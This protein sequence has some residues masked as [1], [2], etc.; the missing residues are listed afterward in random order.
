[1]LEAKEMINVPHIRPNT[2]PPASVSNVA[3]G[4]ERAVTMT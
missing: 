4:K 1:M 3:P 2:A